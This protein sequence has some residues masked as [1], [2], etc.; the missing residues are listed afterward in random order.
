MLAAARAG[1]GIALTRR[2]L[3]A[4]WLDEGKLVRVLDIEIPGESQYYLCT[5]SSRP[6]GGARQAFSLWLEDVC[7]QASQWPCGLRGRPGI[8]F[9]PGA[10]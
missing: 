6:P 1:Q 2:T 3:A 8:N 4:E 7:K 9:Q 10:E 5:E